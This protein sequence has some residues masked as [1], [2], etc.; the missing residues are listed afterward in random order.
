MYCCILASLPYAC[1]PDKQLQAGGQ[2]FPACQIHSTQG[3]SL[4]CCLTCLPPCDEGK[5]VYSYRHSHTTSANVGVTAT[6]LPGEKQGQSFF[7]WA[8]KLGLSLAPSQEGS[9]SRGVATA[10]PQMLF[11]QIGGAGGFCLL[12][13]TDFLPK[14]TWT[15]EL[16][17]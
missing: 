6:L 8:V 1:N 4:Q 7:T 15:T 3:C 16:G 12:S 14:K 9:G 10:C 2:A 17:T 11:Q 13:P 5:C